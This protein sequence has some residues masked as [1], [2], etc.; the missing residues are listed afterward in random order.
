M[1]VRGERLPTSQACKMALGGRLWDEEQAGINRED[2]RGR[3]GEGKGKKSCCSRCNKKVTRRGARAGA[4]VPRGGRALP[5][6]AVQP[7]PA[8]PLFICSPGDLPICT[9][10]LGRVAGVAGVSPCSLPYISRARHRRYFHWKSP[11]WFLC[12]CPPLSVPRAPSPRSPGALPRCFGGRGVHRCAG[13]RAC[14]ELANVGYLVEAAGNFPLLPCHLCVCARVCAAPSPAAVGSGRGAAAA[15]RRGRPAWGWPAPEQPPAPHPHSS[16]QVSRIVFYLILFFPRKEGAEPRGAGGRVCAGDLAALWR[17]GQERGSRDLHR[18]LP[19]PRGPSAGL[20]GDEP[21]RHPP[22]PAPA[23]APPSTPCPTGT[24]VNFCPGSP[25]P[26]R[27]PRPLGI[28]EGRTLRPRSLCP[29][30]R[31]SGFCYGP[32]SDAM[33]G[34]GSRT[35]PRPGAPRT[36]PAGFVPRR[37]CT[38]PR[39]ASQRRAVHSVWKKKKKELYVQAGRIIAEALDIAIE[40]TERAGGC[41]PLPGPGSTA[42]RSRTGLCISRRAGAGASSA[43]GGAGLFVFFWLHLKAKRSRRGEWG[44]GRLR[45]GPLRGARPGSPAVPAAPSPRPAPLVRGESRRGSQLLTSAWPGPRWKWARR[46]RAALGAPPVIGAASRA[47]PGGSGHRA[48]PRRRPGNADVHTG[49]GRSNL[50]AAKSATI[51]NSG[52]LGAS[53]DG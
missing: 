7:S 20:R 48:R 31:V 25:L 12:S 3:G 32:I 2:R 42:P 11:R 4:R 45:A 28:A 46:R 53:R 14:L 26:R 13:H 15:A 33:D 21:G 41:P 51:E 29:S 22:T 23:P 8:P 38:F 6:S 5:G 52:G 9:G 16:L 24:A 1:W 39:R 34:A 17:R 10:P 43:A 50:S 44:R 36:L 37:K 35:L 27:P 30:L 40:G 49:S 47:P 18:L 19:A